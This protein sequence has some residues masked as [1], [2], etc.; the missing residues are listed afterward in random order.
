MKGDSLRA[1]PG[2]GRRPILLHFNEAAGYVLGVDLGRT[3]YALVIT[4]LAANVIARQSGPCDPNRPRSCWRPA[5]AHHGHPP[6]H[7]VATDRLGRHRRKSAR[8][9]PVRWMAHGAR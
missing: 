3:H 6:I 4:D 7:G 5:T 2:G 1:A 9:F 8:V